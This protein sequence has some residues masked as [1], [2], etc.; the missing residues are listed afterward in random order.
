M[1][2]CV[3]L[4]LLHGFGCAAA[5]QMNVPLE[6]PTLLKAINTEIAAESY[7]GRT[8]LKVSDAARGSVGDHGRMV[9]LPAVA[10][11]NGEIEVDVAGEPGPGAAGSARGFIGIAFRIRGAAER[12]EYFYMRPTNGRAED[13][14]RRNHSL[15][16]AAHPGFPWEVLR[17]REPGRYESYADMEPAQWIHI[18]MRVDGR[19]ARFFIDG[20]PQPALIVDDLKLGADG[21]AVGLWI[22]PGTL[23]HFANLRVL[24]AP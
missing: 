14:V 19:K 5:Q 9:L 24:A 3:L 8:S 7:L 20:A 17:D 15:Q 4:V 2:R 13:Q 21:G 23:G 16:Y 10:F 12:F 18:R 11:R 1:R 22:G 6:A